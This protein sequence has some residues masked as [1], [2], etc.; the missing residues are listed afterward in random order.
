M[1]G[2]GTWTYYDYSGRL[3]ASEIYK[4]GKLEGKQLYYSEKDLLTYEEIIF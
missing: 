1:G 4:N 3:N 2:T